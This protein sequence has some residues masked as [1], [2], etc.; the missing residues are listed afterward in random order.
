MVPRHLVFSVAV[1]LEGALLKRWA[2]YPLFINVT[3]PLFDFAAYHSIS[4]ME[5]DGHF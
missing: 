3:L 2:F 1:G 5:A 4:G